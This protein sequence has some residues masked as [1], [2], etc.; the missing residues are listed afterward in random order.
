M[1]EGIDLLDELEEE[2][3]IAEVVNLAANT[4]P[5]R[6]I[7]RIL[8]SQKPD[9]DF[10]IEEGISI[11]SASLAYYFGKGLSKTQLSEII[12]KNGDQSFLAALYSQT[13]SESVITCLLP[14][15]SPV[16]VL[17]QYLSLRNL[18]QPEQEEENPVLQY[19]NTSFTASLAAQEL[20][21][22]LPF[23]EEQLE[24]IMSP[25]DLRDV[26]L[27]SQMV[28]SAEDKNLRTELEALA[29]QE[30]LTAREMLDRGARIYFSE[31]FPSYF[32]LVESAQQEEV[33]KD[34]AK[35]AL[36]E[37]FGD[38]LKTYEQAACL[39]EL[40]DDP[41]IVSNIFSWL[42]KQKIMHEFRED[43]KKHE[44][45]QPNFFETFKAIVSEYFKQNGL[46]ADE[47]CFFRPA[48]KDDYEKGRK[49]RV[50]PKSEFYYDYKGVLG[51]AA[52][53]TC[54]RQVWKI[55]FDG[56]GR[57]L[58]FPELEVAISLDEFLPKSGRLSHRGYE[59]LC[60]EFMLEH[61]IE[62]P[63]FEVGDKV[64]VVN[65]GTNY[66]YTKDGSWGYVERITE[67]QIDIEFHHLTGE[68]HTTPVTFDIKKEHVRSLEER[69]PQEDE[70]ARFLQIKQEI[71]SAGEVGAYLTRHRAIRLIE[72]RLNAIFE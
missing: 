28:L 32:A 67:D 17:K 43:K 29:A 27:F 10:E 23:V 61:L 15:A 3:T 51:T 53:C 57:C 24:R 59:Q 58:P 13:D 45:S 19:T 22:A 25:S 56:D 42:D 41:K 54:G 31:T 11:S 21:Q 38:S 33:D 69:K 40:V 66:L 16:H 18:P 5:V 30:G 14:A 7:A 71:E 64:E 20:L 39:S 36:K 50:S 1:R 9:F 48:E 63:E 47:E 55:N 6:K 4:D 65:S 72:E 60:T 8:E 46:N 62:R 49:F 37:L 35:Q 68:H 70:T 2:E 34:V 44:E 52:G 12:R 26:I